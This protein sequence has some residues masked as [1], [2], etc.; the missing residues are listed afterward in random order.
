LSTERY[1]L[2]NAIS[3]ILGANRKEL[4]MLGGNLLS[5]TNGKLAKTI[6]V[7]SSRAGEGRTTT[8]VAI[9][10][11]LATESNARVLLVDADTV[12]PT[13]HTHFGIEQ[14]PG[15][16]GCTKGEQAQGVTESGIDR[17]SVMPSGNAPEQTA[18]FLTGDGIVN[19]LEAWSDLYD[20]IVLDTSP[21]LSTP[22]PSLL[23]PHVNGILLV[24]ECE[25]TKWQVLETAQEKLIGAG[26]NVLGVILNK[27]RY[28]IPK[29]LYGSV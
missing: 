18:R 14:T 23:A 29:F 13:L 7:T 3:R 1:M 25:R 11:A 5:A 9:A 28:Y 17:L 21:A 8:A 24:A 22:T 26:G 15:L 27:R 10:H 6:L 4:G 16:S 19:L 12:S 20:H 2:S